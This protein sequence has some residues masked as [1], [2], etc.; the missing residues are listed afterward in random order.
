MVSPSMARPALLREDVMLPSIFHS[1][2]AGSYT[3]TQ[4]RA[5]EPSK[6]PTTNSFPGQRHNTVQGVCKNLPSKRKKKKKKASF[7]SPTVW[8]TCMDGN[9]GPPAGHVHGGYEGPSVVLGVVAFHRVQAVPRLC[10]SSHIHEVLQLAHCCLVPP[11]RAKSDFKIQ[12]RLLL[13]R[14]PGGIIQSGIV[15][16]Y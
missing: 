12:S 13:S 6:P 10:S 1:S 16:T 7:C 9:T 14:V 2:R 4:R 3:S 5:W 8:L 15:N 11:C